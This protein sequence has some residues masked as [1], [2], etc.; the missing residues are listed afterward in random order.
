MV[1]EIQASLGLLR[2][3]LRNLVSPTRVKMEV[4]G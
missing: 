3:T 1:H 4:V 2:L